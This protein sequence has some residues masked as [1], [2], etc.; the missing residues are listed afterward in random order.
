MADPKTMLVLILLYA[1]RFF[2][3]FVRRNKRMLEKAGR[4]LEMKRT[5]WPGVGVHPW[6]V[7]LL[8][9]AVIF[10]RGIML[11]I[12]RQVQFFNALR[13]RLC[14]STLGTSMDIA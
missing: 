8:T 3:M 2:E 7:D 13:Y 5:L 11:H 10:R 12:P 1:K 6:Q 4:E 9:C 14:T